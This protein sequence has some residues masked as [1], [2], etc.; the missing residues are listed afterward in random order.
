MVCPRGVACYPIN[1]DAQ[2]EWH[3]RFFQAPAP[4]PAPIV[5]ARAATP[6]EMSSAARTAGTMRELA[7]R[8]RWH[9]NV[10]YARGTTQAA[11]GKPGREAESLALRMRYPG[12]PPGK[13]G[14]VAVWLDRPTGGW[15]FDMA[16]VWP[17]TGEAFPIVVT[18]EE[19]KFVI[20]HVSE[21]IDQPDS[22]RWRSL[23]RMI[24]GYRTER[25]SARARNAAERKAGLPLAA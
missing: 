20:T 12:K 5:P 19:L 24:E 3:A 2:K 8:N 23:A 6:E 16:R 9:A 14:A 13:V 10:T 1:L 7:L 22:W 17:C 11:N 25:V 4:H 15:A 18:S 21:V